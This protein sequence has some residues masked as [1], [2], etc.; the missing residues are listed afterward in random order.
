MKKQVFYNSLGT[1]GTLQT[2]IFLEGI[3]S[4][5]VIQLTADEGKILQN[6]NNFTSLIRVPESE[7]DNW[8]EVE[9]SQGQE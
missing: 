2:P 5:K 9:I 8:K 7:V 6:G 4:T 3:Y 1:N